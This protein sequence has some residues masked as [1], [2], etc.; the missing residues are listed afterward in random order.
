L[1]FISRFRNPEHVPDATAEFSSS[2]AR[3]VLDAACAQAG[4]DSAGAE[5]LR[6]GENAMFRLASAP[7]VA[8][9]ARS[10]DRLGRVEKE[11]CVARWL[12]AADVPAVRVAEDVD[13][14]VVADGHPVSFWQMVTGGDPEP[15][16]AD[17][18]RL[19]ASFHALGDGPCE[20]PSFDPLGPSFTRLAR[21]AGILDA[22]R[23]YLYERCTEMAQ[24]YRRLEF[25]LPVG[26]IHGDAWAG[27]L[28][29]DQ[30]QVVLLDFESA[31][32]GPREWDLM[33]TAV[34]AERYGLP[35]E[36]YEQFAAAYGFDVRDWAGYPV[37]REVRQLTM[38]TWIMQN[39]G[40]SA[41]VAAEFSLRVNSLRERD[42]AR[43]WNTF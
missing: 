41:A 39:A 26:P 32:T 35:E 9:I 15:T 30:G 24:Q 29:T 40:E 18:A 11:L 6:I 22:D 8:R 14:P 28:L 31:A 2:A 36:R 38:T 43:A 3:P 23:D 34:A 5:L 19:L 42:F 4:L 27:N 13:Q 37:L 1:T 33:P 12:A 10:P 20:L 17:L 7:V 25:A 21:A 16:H